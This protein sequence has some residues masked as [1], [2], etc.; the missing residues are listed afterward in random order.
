MNVMNV[1]KSEIDGETKLLLHMYSESYAKRNNKIYIF[2][3]EKERDM[4][5]RWEIQ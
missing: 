1:M 3:K 5:R 4:L 2:E